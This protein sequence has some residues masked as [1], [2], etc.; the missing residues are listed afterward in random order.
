MADTCDPLNRLPIELVIQIFHC[1][2]PFDVWSLRRTCQRWNER[3]SSSQLTHDA[4]KRFATENH[5]DSALGLSADTSLPLA[6]ELRHVLALRLAR[7]FTHVSLPGDFGSSTPA[8]STRKSLS[9]FR[10]KGRHIAYIR[11]LSRREDNSVV[12]RNLMSGNMATLRGEAREHIMSLALSTDLVAFA[13]YT[14]MLYVASLGD[15]TAP[16]SPVRLP[17]SYVAVMAAEGGIVACVLTGSQPVVIIHEAASRKST[18]FN[19]GAAQVP[20]QQTDPKTDLRVCAITINEDR[21]TVDI[22]TVV[23]TSGQDRT[24]ETDMRVVVSRFSFAGEYV[25]Q[26]VWEQQIPGLEGM[27]AFLGPFEA[28]GERGLHSLELDYRCMSSRSGI[29]DVREAEDAD[30]VVVDPREQVYVGLRLLYDEAEVSLKSVDHTMSVLRT[31]WGYPSRPL[32]WKDRLYRTCPHTGPMAAFVA[33]SRS[34]TPHGPS[35]DGP[36]ALKRL[37]GH[38]PKDFDDGSLEAGLNDESPDSD[39]RL[40]PLSVQKHP[41]G[42]PDACHDFITMNDTFAVTLCS[43]KIEVACFDERV[44]LHGAESTKLWDPEYKHPYTLP[45][46]V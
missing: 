36:H 30:A 4:V 46:S 23:S 14:G 11:G 8:I 29:R 26:V 19:F 18:S 7:P 1:L 44:T 41:T 32:C 37:D 15:I 39:S 27:P 22:A 38:L 43:D 21:E 28:T 13:T 45:S 6:L 5:G 35:F 25:T 12:V 33:A 3:L 42:E 40:W 2:H 20:E 31:T 10:L 34:S 16:P 17:S 9:R 24:E